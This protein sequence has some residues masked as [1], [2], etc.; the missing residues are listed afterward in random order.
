[1]KRLILPAAKADLANTINYEQV[2]I[3]NDNQAFAAMQT[4]MQS[5]A[6]LKHS[7]ESQKK[8]DRLMGEGIPRRRRN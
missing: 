3:Q 7:I 6:D 4:A 5:E 1:M 2:Q 8:I